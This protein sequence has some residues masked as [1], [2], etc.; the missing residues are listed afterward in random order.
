M[1][2][3]DEGCEAEFEVIGPLDEVDTLV[4]DCGSGLAV[5]GWPAPLQPRERGVKDRPLMVE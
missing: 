4:C 5:I 3:S 2:C 1:V